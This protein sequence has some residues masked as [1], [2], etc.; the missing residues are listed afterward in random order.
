MPL[1]EEGLTQLILTHSGLQTERQGFLDAHYQELADYIAPSKSNI[2]RKSTNSKR[3]E[4]IFD[5]T[6]PNSLA[7][8]V[9]AIQGTL[10]PST[11]KWFSLRGEDDS[12]LTEV[13]DQMFLA[14]NNSNF[15]ASMQLCF[16][17]LL[18]F[19]SCCLF[20]SERNVSES[21]NFA[22]LRFKSFQPGTFVI[23]ENSDG[24]VDTVMR[25]FEFT[26]LQTVQQYG[27]ENLS[28]KSK[29]LL[30]ENKLNEKIKL[31]HVSM[32]RENRDYFST[33]K[34][35]KPFSQFVLELENEN[36]GK[37]LEESGTEVSPYIVARWK[38][39]HYGRSPGMDILPD[40][41][42]LNTAVKMR[43]EAWAKAINP[44]YLVNNYGIFGNLDLRPG[45]QNPVKANVGEA[46]QE[47]IT[48][49]RFDVANFN[50][51]LLRNSIRQGLFI[52]QIQFPPMEGTPVSATE[53]SGRFEMMQRV[54]GPILG[55][56]ENEFLQGIL[57]R[58]F[59]LMQSFFTLD[60]DILNIQFDGPLARTQRSS[61]IES[62]SRYYQVAL[63]I[64]QSK[65]EILDG[66]NHQEIGVFLAERSGVP[67]NLISSQEELDAITESRQ[68]AQDAANEQEE[69]LSTAKAAH[70]TAPLAKVL[71]EVGQDPNLQSGV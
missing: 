67:G 42:S 37:I 1:T 48:Q 39:N 33:D 16:E 3:N 19:G 25:E 8:A 13:S 44:P 38:G 5:S 11:I 53:F 60:T 46:V 47:L 9:S 58:S 66:V 35:N 71:N 14:L 51:E 26:L 64:S 57:V 69:A 12:L 29:A 7:I 43:F 22:G 52:D 55:R 10:T 40:V 18:L 15:A 20:I 59:S 30:A 24:A 41:R 50:E 6:A 56:L 27:K 36:T 4:L 62:V 21:G 2:L 45:A 70:D 61:D 28:D 49:S 31:L 32:P 54:L 17:D 65:P 63:P 34:F 68:Q 23:M